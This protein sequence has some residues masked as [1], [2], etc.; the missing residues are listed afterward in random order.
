MFFGC[1]FFYHAEMCWPADAV[2]LFSVV[3]GHVH[4]GAGLRGPSQ[5]S[6]NLG[7]V[8][9]CLFVRNHVELHG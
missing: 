3:W 7:F 9:F 1:T 4:E 2:V 8:L 5:C 6:A